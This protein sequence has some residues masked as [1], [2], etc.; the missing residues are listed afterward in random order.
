MG[1][2]ITGII[3]VIIGII[4]VYYSQSIYNFTGPID[5]IESK[6]PG[7]TVGFIKLIAVILI[8]VGIFMATGIFG[9]ITK[10]IWE[11]INNAFGGVK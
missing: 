8:V 7:N 6:M 10:P 9:F 5:F 3:F 1:I 11:G 2:I 4:S